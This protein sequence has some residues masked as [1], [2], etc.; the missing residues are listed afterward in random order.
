MISMSLPASS[1]SDVVY[2]CSGAAVMGDI[3]RGGEVNGGGFVSFPDLRP[4]F[5]LDLEY[6]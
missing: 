2:D 3:A 6:N 1:D 5:S 4:L